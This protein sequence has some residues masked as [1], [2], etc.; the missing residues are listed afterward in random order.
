M[1]VL[2]VI[3]TNVVV[4]AG[5]NP[6]GHPA[7]IVD[8]ALAGAIVPVVCPTVTAEYV[9]VV[10][11]SI[12]RKWKFPPLWLDAFISGSHLVEQEPPLWPSTGPDPDDL[13][14]LS[15]AHLTGAVLVTGNVADFPVR[16]RHG[17][18]VVNPATYV[19]H[20]DELGIHW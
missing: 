8:A 2:V 10:M 11:R 15:L 7:R 17:V 20:L 9:A 18:V 6:T 14:F 12:F 5:I 3:D 19:K 1:S 16:I 13:V 4:S